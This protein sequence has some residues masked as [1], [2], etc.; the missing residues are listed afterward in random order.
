LCDTTAIINTIIVTNVAPLS[1]RTTI[2]DRMMAGIRLVTIDVTGTIFKLKESPSLV[3]SRL[4]ASHGVHCDP[5]FIAHAFLRSYKRMNS[6]CPHFGATTGLT[7]R[8]WWLKIVDDTFRGA[9]KEDAYRRAATVIPAVAID[10][11]DLYATADPYE[12]FLDFSPF[13]KRLKGVPMMALSNFDTRLHT[14]LQELQVAHHFK[15][16]VTSEEAESSKPDGKIFAWA[17]RMSGIGARPNEIL[18]I[19]DDIANDY[20]G[21]RAVGWHSLLLDRDGDKEQANVAPPHLCRD[22]DDVSR[23][24]SGD[25]EI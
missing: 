15:H 9:L 22:F 8:E 7:S 5:K 24:L 17:A 1:N 6:T 25:R 19:G 11:Y 3:Y 4:A 18:H 10:L 21:P 12:L 13:A 20:N 2:I 14:I 16:I 23:V